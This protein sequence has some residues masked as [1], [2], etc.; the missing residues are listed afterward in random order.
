MRGQPMRYLAHLHGVA[1][2]VAIAI[3]P[4]HAQGKGDKP[5]NPT[6]TFETEKCKYTLSGADWS[7]VDS[8][9]TGVLC[10]AKDRTG[11]AVIFGVQNLPQPM[12]LTQEFVD[13]FEKGYYSSASMRAKKRGGRFGTFQGLPSYQTEATL[14]DAKTSA[15]RVV[16][17]N[18]RGY[19]VTVVGGKEPVELNS[20]FE[21]IMNGFAF[22]E[23]P[24]QALPE[25]AK[26]SASL[27]YR[28]GEIA[29]YA[30]IVAILL[31]LLARV[32]RRPRR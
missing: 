19:I 13:G 22:T 30:T 1:F 29:G 16:L 27:S 11:G 6:R 32:F 2:L 26:A 4:I 23:P 24:V 14:D 15:G 18:G 9:A 25:S 17:A 10:M 20:T 12:P 7:W 3:S 21:T 28:M 31:A 5:A 8:Q